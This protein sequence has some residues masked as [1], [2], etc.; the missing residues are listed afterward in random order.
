MK[1]QANNL[2]KIFW[3]WI[4]FYLPT[5][6]TC[7]FLRLNHDFII[8]VVRFYFTPVLVLI[9]FTEYG[10]NKFRNWLNK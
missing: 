6:A 1:K 10:Q 9:L 3:Y 4:V 2:Q 5:I 7:I 8:N